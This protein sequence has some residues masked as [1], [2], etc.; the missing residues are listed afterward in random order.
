MP[1]TVAS[2][3]AVEAEP[4]DGEPRECETDLCGRCIL[5]VGGLW[6]AHAVCRLQRLVERRNGSLID[7]D[8][9]MEDNRAMGSGELVRRAD[10]VFFPVDCVKPSRGRRGEEPV[11]GAMEFP[12]GGI[13]QR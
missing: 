6:P 7:H 10:A 4:R 1:P 13:A 8:G 12:M 11:R 3:I 5:D 9:G 2:E